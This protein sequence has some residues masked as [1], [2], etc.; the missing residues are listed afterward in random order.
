MLTCASFLIDVILHRRVVRVYGLLRVAFCSYSALGNL[1]RAARLFWMLLDDR[2]RHSKLGYFHRPPSIQRMLLAD[3]CSISILFEID[4]LECVCRLH[5]VDFSRPPGDYILHRIGRLCVL[6]AGMPC[7]TLYGC[8]VGRAHGSSD[9]LNGVVAVIVCRVR[10]PGHYAV[11]K[12][13]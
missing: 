6:P 11:C 4:W 8:R 13:R 10:H 12:H 2:R 3:V 9:R 7:R 1:D 5:V